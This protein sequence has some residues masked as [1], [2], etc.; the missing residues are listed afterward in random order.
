MTGLLL[1]ENRSS[2]DTIIAG[3]FVILAIAL[4]YGALHQSVPF[5]LLFTG[6]SVAF[7]GSA[8]GIYTRQPVLYFLALGC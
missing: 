8:I 7:V 1:A 4:G 6:I 2:V 3:G 5:A